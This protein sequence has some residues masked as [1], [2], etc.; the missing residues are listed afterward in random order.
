MLEIREAEITAI[1]AEGYLDYL[2][3][4]GDPELGERRNAMTIKEII[5]EYL[6]ENGFDGL[7]FPGECACRADD[8]APCENILPGCQPG[9]LGP[10]P[11]TCGEHD[12]HI[13]LIGQ[14]PKVAYARPT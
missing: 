1:S 4:T 6:K 11:K 5:T 14:G 13:A 12:W 8:L 3:E 2:T 7:F 9:Y 10:C